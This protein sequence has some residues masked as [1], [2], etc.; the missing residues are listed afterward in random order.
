MNITLIGGS[1]FGCFFCSILRR[2]HIG[3][4]IK[5]IL[6]LSIV[7]NSEKRLLSQKYLFVVENILFIICIILF[8]SASSDER[9]ILPMDLF[10]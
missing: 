2:D 10:D 9:F 8:T 1:D 5:C 4:M 7:M 3:R 6:Y